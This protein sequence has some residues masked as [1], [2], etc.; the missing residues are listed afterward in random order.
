MCAVMA[1]GMMLYNM[2]LHGSL[3]LRG[4][5]YGFLPI[6][7]AAYLIDYFA[8]NG[9]AV[10]AVSKIMDF[11]GK[12]HLSRWLFPGVKV[13]GM[14]VCMSGV[15]MLIEVGLTDHFGE[16]YLASLARNYPVALPLQLLVAGPSSRLLLKGY[17]SRK[18]REENE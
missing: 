10:K 5:A 13:L 1:S 17:R 2:A 18:G 15:A 12:H 8:V 14:V 9:M 11:Y 4:F 3:S 7:A 6:F 16:D